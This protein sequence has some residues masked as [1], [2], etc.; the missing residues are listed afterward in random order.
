MWNSII[1]AVVLG[2]IFLVYGIKKRKDFFRPAFLFCTV[3]MST[4]FLDTLRL[5]LLQKE[6]PIW[7]TIVIILMCVFFGVGTKGRIKIVIRKEKKYFKINYRMLCLVLWLAIVLSFFV[8]VRM[9]GAP[10]AI[11]KVNRAE[12]FISGWGTILL[13]YQLLFGLA[14]YDF[15]NY[16]ILGKMKWVYI[17]TAIFISLMLSNKYQLISLLILFL[18]AKNSFG[19]R[20]NVKHLIIVL[21]LIITMFIILYEFVYHQMYNVSMDEMYIGYKMIIPERLSF[22]TTPYLY[23]AYNYQNLYH[24]ILNGSG[25]TYGA[26]TFGGGLEILGITEKLPEIIKC[27]MTEW[28][29]ILQV[30]SLT[31]G[32]LFKDFAMD[33][34][35]VW[36][37][38]G[39]FCCGFFSHNSYRYF[40]RE[41]SFLSFY[42]YSLVINAIVLSFFTN[43]FTSK[44]TIINLLMAIG[45][46]CFVTQ[47]IT[48]RR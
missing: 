11:S 24:Y 27:R 35:L 28:Q 12:Y 23:I 34:G 10:P 21:V 37:F 15:Y 9:L 38:L 5:S 36:M 8:T 31:T 42:L 19:K 43:A 22:L 25:Y 14:I 3:I 6:Y 7:F 46:E 30:D 16:N 39:T 4:F 17:A 1:S 29:T 13:L 41:K 33:G 44:I 26:M 32:T 40:Q 20:L 45:V 47:K 18:V 48:L 2:G